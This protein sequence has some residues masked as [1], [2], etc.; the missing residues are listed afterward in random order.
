MENCSENRIEITKKNNFQ[1]QTILDTVG[2]EV[3]IVWYAVWLVLFTCIDDD[4][5]K[6][7]LTELIILM[8]G[9]LSN[10]HMFLYF[11]SYN[12]IEMLLKY[13]FILIWCT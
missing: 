4:E 10:Y 7:Y 11:K 6:T 3:F 5:C 1:Y 9:K 13:V 8:A 12:K 2:N